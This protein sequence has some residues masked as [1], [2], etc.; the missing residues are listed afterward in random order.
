MIE[1]ER[2]FEILQGVLTTSGAD[3][4]EAIFIGNQKGLTRF[5]NNSIH[6]NVAERDT[7]VIFRVALGKRVGVATANSLNKGR[8]IDTLKEAV[9]IAKHQVENPHFS[10]LPSAQEYKRLETFFEETADFTPEERAERVGRI[11]KMVEDKGLQ[12]AGALSTSSGE[13]AVLNS[14]GVAAYQPLSAATLRIVVSSA[15]SSGYA[16]S[17]CR[18]IG[19]LDV[20]ER[21]EVA[22]KRCLESKGPRDLK[23]GRYDVLLEPPAVG[24]LIEWMSMIGFGAK[25]LQEETSFLSDRLGERIVSEKV[26]IYDDGND[27]SG[28]AMPFDFEGIPK[29]RVYFIDKG[30]AQGV[31]YD[32]ETANREGKTST[33]HAL[34]PTSHSGPMPL[35]VFFAP[36][37]EGEE[38]MLNSMRRGILVTRFHYVNGL[39]NTREALFTG[40]TRDGTFFVEDGKV[41]YPI[42]NLRFTE[43]ML[44]ALSNVEMVSRE[45][46][47]INAW[48]EAVGAAVVPSLLIKD[49]NF[50]GKTSGQ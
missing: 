46:K 33:G 50:S 17:L 35:N 30:V 28:I 34:P 23:P 47:A 27:P 18:D 1:R 25:S 16:D 10:S 2:V 3:Q 37:D 4:T 26:T 39:L 6:Q 9:K 20:D 40:M 41:K 29:Q 12:V 38:E 48:W 7:S 44:K 5:A 21:T 14:F 15:D 43:S 31:V 45:R 42:E 8:L 49:F 11:I 36:G 22:I 24:E 32:S 19:E 13:I